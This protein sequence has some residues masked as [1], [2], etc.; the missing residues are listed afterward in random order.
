MYIH[1]SLVCSEALM[2][3]LAVMTVGAM[4]IMAQQARASALSEQAG[5]A[6]QND[7][8][9]VQ[10]C[11]LPQQAGSRRPAMSFSRNGARSTGSWR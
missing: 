9:T 10:A 11:Q 8:S 7:R 1:G 4:G 6:L 2:M 3:A 5:I